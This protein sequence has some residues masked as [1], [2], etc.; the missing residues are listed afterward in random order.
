[1]TACRLCAIGFLRAGTPRIRVGRFFCARG[2]MGPCLG[3]AR[4]PE[5]VRQQVDLNASCFRHPLAPGRPT[6]DVL[7]PWQFANEMKPGDVIVAK[8]GIKEII[9]RGVVTGDYVYDADA[10]HYRTVR[11]GPLDPQGK[12]SLTSRGR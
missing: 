12:L 5:G 8:R 2:I 1:M 7:A 10:E 11:V 6:N 4:R 3:G 9:G